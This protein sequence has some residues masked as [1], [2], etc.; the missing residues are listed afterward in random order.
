MYPQAQAAPTSISTMKRGLSPVYLKVGWCLHT[1][2]L[3]PARIRAAIGVTP[4]AKSAHDV[5]RPRV[6]DGHPRRGA[7]AGRDEQ[8]GDRRDSSA[9]PA[10]PAGGRG[11]VAA[12]SPRARGA[13]LRARRWPP[14]HRALGR[15][16]GVRVSGRPAGADSGPARAGCQPVPARARRAVLSRRRSGGGSRAAGLPLGPIACVASRRARQR[17]GA[18]DPRGCAPPSCAS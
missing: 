14:R 9:D 1:A 18:A 15:A 6:A 12:G 17:E 10:G 4:H 2:A 13:A 11:R 3:I 8:P 7:S 16:G 5:A